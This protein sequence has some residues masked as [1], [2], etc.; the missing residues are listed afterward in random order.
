MVNMKMIY[1]GIVADNEMPQQMAF[2]GIL[3]VYIS[4]K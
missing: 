1:N 2:H 3:V 4:V